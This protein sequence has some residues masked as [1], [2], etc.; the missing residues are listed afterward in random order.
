[1]WKRIALTHS[2][3]SALAGWQIAFNVGDK[4]DDS[5]GSSIKRLL[6][7]GPPMLLNG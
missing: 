6:Q 5:F 2:K 7:Q 1:M 4:P 3:L